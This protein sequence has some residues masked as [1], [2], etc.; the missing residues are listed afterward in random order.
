MPPAMVTFS[1][2]IYQKHF[3]KLTS[4]RSSLLSTVAMRRK[5]MERKR[6]P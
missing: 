3:Q 5:E 6:S 1:S 2:G 4:L